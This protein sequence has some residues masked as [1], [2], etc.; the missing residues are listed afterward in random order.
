MY[1]T[2]SARWMTSTNHAS[3]RSRSS[4]SNSISL[5]GRRQASFKAEAS[6]DDEANA[7]RQQRPQRKYAYDG[8][9]M[10]CG[11]Y[12]HRTGNPS[13]PVSPPTSAMGSTGSSWM[14]LSPSGT[15]CWRQCARGIASRQ[16]VVPD[17]FLWHVPQ[18]TCTLRL[19]AVSWPAG[20]TEETHVQKAQGVSGRQP[21]SQELTPLGGGEFAER[22]ERHSPDGAPAEAIAVSATE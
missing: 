9:C 5:P 2:T 19:I 18:W 3:P 6:S 11:K 12:G 22:S 8:N 20:S 16:P 14:H 1:L 17:V 4:V 10:K 21:G 15:W 13:A 7:A